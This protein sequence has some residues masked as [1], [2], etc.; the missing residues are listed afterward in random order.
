MVAKTKGRVAAAVAGLLLADGARAL[1][2]PKP[3]DRSGRVQAGVASFYSPKESGKTTASGEPLKPAALTAASRTLPLGTKA[4]VVNKD[5]GRAVTV[6]I[7][8]RGPY[9]DGRVVD[10]TPKAAEKLG[11]TEEGVASV[12]VKPLAEPPARPPVQPR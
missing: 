4:Q 9:V 5:N 3:I 11:M 6:T 8:D 7:N 1:A 2:Q 12:E 10:V